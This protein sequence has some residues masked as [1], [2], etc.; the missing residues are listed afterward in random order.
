M[1]SLII[2][3]I[4]SG[5]SG[6]RLWPLSTPEKP[7]PY[8]KFGADQSLFQQTVQRCLQAGFDRRPIV[9]ASISHR[10]HLTDDL[11][12]CGVSADI[13]LEPEG[14]DSCAAA[15][16]GAMLAL[17]RDPDALLLMLAADHHIPDAKAFA[18]AVE[19]ARPQA[20]AGHLV[21]FG[22]QP[23]MPATGYGYILPDHPIA[24][25]ELAPVQ[26][27]AEKP[28]AA[29]ALDYM[30]A[31]YLW[32]SGNLL[33]KAAT[34]VVEVE[35]HA[36]ELFAAVAIALWN[37]RRDQHD[38][39]LD[40][41]A[42]AAVPKIS[43]DYAILEKTRKA[44]VMAVDHDWSDI[45]TWDAVADLQPI[46][47]NGNACKAFVAAGRNNFVHAENQLTILSKVDDLLVI[48]TPSAI[49]ITR[50]G[51]GQSVRELAAKFSDN[52]KPQEIR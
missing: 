29:T 49:L 26:R 8:L 12:N 25:G 19:T 4:L 41:Q 43:V 22:I 32:N 13:I 10:P 28:D 6:R 34:F 9:V 38:W 44:W 50:K 21:S 30:K 23:K 1:T 27:F 40:S 3:M 31:G 11:A 46:D 37:S 33:F 52:V 18:K 39:H 15:L 42:Y 17:Q 20:E 48:T 16:A 7:K 24:A 45:G 36:P 47:S 35:H 14:R 5:G 2:P 51:Q